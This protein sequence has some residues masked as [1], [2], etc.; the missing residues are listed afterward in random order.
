MAKHTLKILRCWHLKILKYVWLFYNI[1]HKRVKKVTLVQADSCEFCK[2]FKNNFFIEPF[3]TTK[4]EE[5]SSCMEADIT[6]VIQST[7]SKI[8]PKF[9]SKNSALK[10][11]LEA[12]GQQFVKFSRIALSFIRGVFRTQSNFCDVAFLRK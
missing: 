6:D 4:S 1:M 2:I 12:A 11:F 5:R 3:R 7:C 10:S 9:N 8:F